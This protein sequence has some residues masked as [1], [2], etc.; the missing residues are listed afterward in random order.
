MHYNR[1][2]ATLMILRS[3]ALFATMGV[4]VKLLSEDLS[5]RVIT[6]WLM[7][8]GPVL[9]LLYCKWRGELKYVRRVNLRFAGFRSVT[10]AGNTFLSFYAYTVLPLA[11]ACMLSFL[12]PLFLTILSWLFLKE[13]VGW[14]RWG[15]TVAGFIGVMIMM[16]PSISA[17]AEATAPDWRGHM[18]GQAAGI[19]AAFLNACNFAILRR[20]LQ[21]EVASANVLVTGFFAALIALSVSFSPLVNT[22]LNP[23]I[24]SGLLL[25]V[26]VA[27]LAVISNSEAYQQAEASYL[28]PFGYIQLFWIT[29]G[30]LLIWGEWP[31]AQAWAGAGLIIL[32]GIY[33]IHRERYWER[34]RAVELGRQ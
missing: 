11:E 14:H 4:I 19:T 8:L 3:Q 30:G 18:L 26:T 17:A 29:I 20:R 31:T 7:V 21:T 25:L 23:N 1:H 6:T 22:H 2:A 9:A 16:E 28:A 15:A 5:P 24:I 34:R 13:K 12:T 32:G 33:T 10:V 27:S